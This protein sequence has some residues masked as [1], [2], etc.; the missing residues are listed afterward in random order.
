M[1]ILSCYLIVF[2]FFLT[3]NIR[4]T[5]LK[6][7]LFSLTVLLNNRDSEKYT[8]T[9]PIAINVEHCFTSIDRDHISYILAIM[10]LYANENF[11]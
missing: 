2:I 7:M 11:L 4:E 8:F 3:N 9:I 6:K 1:R 5:K 10:I